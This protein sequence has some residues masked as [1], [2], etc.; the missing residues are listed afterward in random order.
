M[1]HAICS[2]TSNTDKLPQNSARAQ[3][4]AVVK[5]IGASIRE[6]KEVPSGHLYA[7]LC[8][9]LSLDQYQGV[10]SILRE[11]KEITIDKNHL[12]RWIGR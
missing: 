10:L 12:I 3:A 1:T 6:L 8:G 11:A 7:A 2:A 4:L 9:K 5:A